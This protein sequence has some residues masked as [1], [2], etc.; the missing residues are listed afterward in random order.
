[1]ASEATASSSRARSA[2]GRVAPFRRTFDSAT[3]AAER[4]YAENLDFLQPILDHGEPREAVR[5]WL[6]SNAH[7]RTG[8]MK[9]KDLSQTPWAVKMLASPDPV[10]A[11]LR[12]VFAH[13]DGRRWDRADWDAVRALG[14]TLA[15]FAS[16]SAG[17]GP[18]GWTWYPIATEDDDA[19]IL[20]RLSVEGK[21]EA[22][23]RFAASLS[24]REVAAVVATYEREV[25]RLA[26]CM[27]AQRR[28]R[29]ESRLAEIRRWKTEGIPESVCGQGVYAGHTCDLGPLHGELKRLRD[30]CE[31]DAAYTAWL[32]EAVRRS[33]R[34][35]S[36]AK[37]DVDLDDVP[38]EL[39]PVSAFEEDVAAS[40]PA[41]AC[42][43]SEAAR[44]MGRLGAA[45]RAANAAKRRKIREANAAERRAERERV[46][47][48]RKA[49][50][51]RRPSPPKKPTTPEASGGK[52][53]RSQARKVQQK[54][55][56]PSMPGKPAMAE[57]SGA[58]RA[59]PKV[60][61]KALG[62]DLRFFG[63]DADS[64]DRRMKHEEGIAVLEGKP[65]PPWA[66]YVFAF[67]KTRTY[68]HV[69]GSGEHRAS[70]FGPFGLGQHLGRAIER[71]RQGRDAES[72]AE[73]EL[74]MLDTLVEFQSRLLASG[75]FAS[76]KPAADEPRPKSSSKVSPRVLKRGQ[77][78][79][80]TEEQ[81]GFALTP[82][83]GTAAVH[84][85]S[86]G[87]GGTQG[88]LSGVSRKV[89][90][91][92]LTEMTERERARRVAQRTLRAG[93]RRS[94]GGAS[95][96]SGMTTAQL[97]ALVFE[98]EGETGVGSWPKA[99][100]DA[101]HKS[102]GEATAELFAR[103]VLKP[104]LFGERGM[105][106]RPL[107]AVPAE[108]AEE[109]LR[110]GTSGLAVPRWLATNI[111]YVLAPQF[112]G[113]ELTL[114]RGPQSK[115]STRA[116]SVYVVRKGALLAYGGRRA[117]ISVRRHA[118]LYTVEVE[119]MPQSVT[120]I[121]EAGVR[122]VMEDPVLRLRVQDGSALRWGHA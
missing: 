61:A 99:R 45:K 89:S 14:E 16:E 97:Q 35:G 40:E 4:F 51:K 12:N 62:R 11:A 63:R 43:P 3:A 52:E 47:Q 20:D 67:P 49:Q 121:A 66:V 26:R 6:R 15:E 37:A 22:Y 81:A 57:A 80:V 72:L 68:G 110:G 56:R 82:P 5:E 96:L 116:E 54:Q 105:H 50:R 86:A 24:E 76:P 88:V 118:G 115:T 32:N 85:A 1:M 25:K 53:G 9:V 46:S 31:S 34:A 94:P 71:L 27:S 44:I 21:P 106:E 69:R 77:G 39:V 42:T 74:A 36:V 108:S 78:S 103:G 8:R 33:P 112:E 59:K 111:A 65:A 30:A 18:G 79:L 120:R 114:V 38:V 13:A 91:S 41:Q 55:G 58:S 19:K 7:G 92:K 100:A 95:D 107:T 122:R 84:G 23:R 73:D 28:S 98:L 117:R 60:S 102:L 109:A 2:L 104:V 83:R 70:V 29:I 119:G 113:G 75:A 93:P 64:K 101:H 17:A 48:A 90:A 10:K 87:T